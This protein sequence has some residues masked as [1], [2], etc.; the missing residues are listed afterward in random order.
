MLAR[1]DMRD[2]FFGVYLLE[3]ASHIAFYACSEDYQF[4]ELRHF[5][6]KYVQAE[7]FGHV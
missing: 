7:S 6:E 4:I 2:A 3:N 1:E 5:V